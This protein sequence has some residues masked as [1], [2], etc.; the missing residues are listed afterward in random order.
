MNI[1]PKQYI[2]HLIL[3]MVQPL[4]GWLI[5]V[6]KARYDDDRIKN[7]QKYK[8]VPSLTFRA[9]VAKLDGQTARD[10]YTRN[11]LVI[12]ARPYP[13]KLVERATRTKPPA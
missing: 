5:S 4:T 11:R 8:R 6:W 7:Y 3:E 9:I 2:N 13:I 1:A 12:P 10:G